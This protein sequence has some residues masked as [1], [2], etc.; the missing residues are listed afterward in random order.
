M[1]TPNKQ[2]VKLDNI[3]I[4]TEPKVNEVA[5]AAAAAAA[6]KRTFVPNIVKREKKE[7]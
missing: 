2:Q 5:A 3:K 6:P 7:K 4:K 1:S